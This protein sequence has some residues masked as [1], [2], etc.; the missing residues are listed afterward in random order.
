MTAAAAEAYKERLLQENAE[1]RLPGLEASLTAP[2]LFRA[3]SPEGLLTLTI[4]GAQLPTDYLRRVYQ[5]RLTQYLRHGWVNVT[6][7]A[8]RALHGEPYDEMALRDFHTLVIERGSGRLRGY[9]TLAVSR[10]PEGTR[11]GDPAHQPFVAERDYGFRLADYLGEATLSSLVGE[12]KRLI[13]DWAM[14]RSPAAASV[15]WWVYLGWATACLGTLGHPDLAIVGDS[16]KS[17]AIHQLRLLGFS[18]RTLEVPPAIPD[19]DDLFAPM[20]NQFER[21]YPFILTNE[22]ALRPTLEYLGKV[23]TSGDAG[24]ARRR[25]TQF[26]EGNS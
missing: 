3:I 26:R 5:F 9:G 2:P 19:P 21:S 7:V 11:L 8:A 25:L 6:A 23:L 16:K 20:W 24:S 14:P 17:G 12:G 15:P 10:D 18:I 13:R 4:R 1:L 22:G